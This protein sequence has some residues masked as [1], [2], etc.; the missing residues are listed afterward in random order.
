VSVAKLKKDVKTINLSALKKGVKMNITITLDDATQKD[1]VACLTDLAAGY[2]VTVEAF[3]LQMVLRRVE[4]HFRYTFQQV[5]GSVDTATI[6]EKMGSYEEIKA[7][8]KVITNL[9]EKGPIGKINLSEEKA[10]VSEEGKVK[11]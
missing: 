1:E 4:E 10:K 9:A 11:P 5:L 2:G 3:V 7:D 8:L 6:K